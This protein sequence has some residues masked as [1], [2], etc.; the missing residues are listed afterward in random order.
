MAAKKSAAKKSTAAKTGGGRT[1]AASSAQN[2]VD[3][4]LAK[5]RSMRD[6]GV[7]AEPSGG[8]ARNKTPE[9]LPFVIQ[10]HAATRL[11]YDFRLGWNG[12]LKS[13]AVAKGPSYVTRDKRLAVEVEDH[14][15]E[16]GGFEGTIPKGQYGGGTVM[17]WD[18]GTWEPQAEHDF[19]EGL[20]KGSLKFILHG[21]KLQGKWALIRMGGKAAQESKPNWLLIKEHDQYERSEGDE[22][23]TE[24]EPDSALT[25]R[26]MEEIGDASDHVWQSNRP[27]VP[28]HKSAESNF[29]DR[30]RAKFA[31][32]KAP[33][34][35]AAAQAAP[36]EAATKSART[37]KSTKSAPKSDTEPAPAAASRFLEPQLAVQA[38]APPRGSEWIHEL[39]LDGYRIQAHIRRGRAGVSL[40]TRSGLDWTHRMQPIADALAALSAHTAVLDGEV[41]VLDKDG[42]PSFAELQAAFQD[43]VRKPLTYFVFDVLQI[44]G[45]DLRQSPLLE[46]KRRLLELLENAPAAVRFTE[47]LEGNGETL[48]DEACTMGA[49]GLISKRADSKYAGG[50]HPSWVKAK[51]VRRQEFVIGGW[52]P[53]NKGNR[54][55]GALLLGYYRNGELIYAGRTGTGFTHASADTICKRLQKMET[56][57]KPFAGTLPQGAGKNA[58]W[59][60]PELV[61][62]VAFATWTADDLVRQASFQGMREDKKAREVRKEDAAP[63]RKVERAAEQEV[64]AGSANIEGAGE[65]AEQA[66]T[67]KPAPPLPR[68][69]VRLTN[70]DK[71]LDPLSGL[72]KKQYFDYILAA[73]EHILPHI[74]DRPLTMVR[75]PEGTSGQCFYQKHM[76]KG[77]PAGVEPIPVKMKSGKEEDFVTLHTV[78]ALA[79]L[80]Q[81]GVLE[82]HPW[83]SRNETLEQPDRLIFDLDPDEALP[84]KTVAEAAEEVRAHLAELKL[85][86]FVK[87]TGGKG[88]HIVAPLTPQ[89]EWPEFKALAHAFVLRMEHDNPRLY[90]TKMS[91]AARKGKIFL[92]YL[93]N[94]RGATAVAAWSAR[95]RPGAT[96][97]VPLTWEELPRLKSAPKYEVARFSEWRGRLD[98]DPW[99]EMGKVR[100]R[101]SQQAVKALAR[102]VA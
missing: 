46:R 98:S 88:L 55:I 9:G 102:F 50:R 45:Q 37:K 14:P 96:V 26:S 92:D 7:T 81:M 75:C 3:D 13:W 63:V 77:M 89:L 36:R 33:A 27:E 51:C 84:W 53:P 59:V 58:H 20:K 16:Y 70:P 39:K 8:Q 28:Q 66:R 74:A 41:V 4:Q 72:T 15:I 5:Y 31:A 91:K 21:K 47:H 52:T 62:E 90:L 57:R 56:D 54:G 71:T 78:E 64:H 22:P 60:K 101:F 93:R 25:G 86:S 10:K 29:R 76:G 100:Q 67:N 61:C 2:I 30:L 85:Q 17:V 99:L 6:F 82:L 65:T 44:D 43:H 11:H 18:T 48:F 32:K 38:D 12:V 34:K 83:G 42:Q 68:V 87:S 69:N 19:D 97:A 1:K 49:E 23:I 95:A 24:A 40:Y 94:E 79:G 73:G 80:A 35:T